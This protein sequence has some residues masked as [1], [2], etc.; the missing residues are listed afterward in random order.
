MSNITAKHA[1]IDRRWARYHRQKFGRYDR[2]RHRAAE[3][4]RLAAHRRRQNRLDF[5]PKEV[6]DDIF[7]NPRVWTARAIGHRLKLTWTE[8]CNLGIRTMEPYDLDPADLKRKKLQ[9]RAMLNRQRQARFK[10]RHREAN[11][12]SST[13]QKRYRERKKALRVTNAS[14]HLFKLSE[15][16][17][18]MDVYHVF[19]PMHTSV[20]VS[21]NATSTSLRYPDSSHRK[22]PPGSGIID[23]SS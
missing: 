13:R 15:N 3:V 4:I 16:V 10:R 8:R 17:E 22:L 14:V 2:G 18:Q 9:R 1:E 5:D 6:I 7:A 23:V 11:A 20:T 12:E 21:G 19:R